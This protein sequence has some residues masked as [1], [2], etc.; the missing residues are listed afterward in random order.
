MVIVSLFEG[1][2]VQTI[3]GG[4]CFV[5]KRRAKA[6]REQLAVQF[7]R[8]SFACASPVFLRYLRLFDF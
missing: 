4:P 3:Q 1:E 8:Q 2:P 7:W 6:T 5:A